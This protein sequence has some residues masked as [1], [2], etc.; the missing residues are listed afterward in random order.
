MICSTNNRR[1]YQPEP[2][3]KR[4]RPPRLHLSN[5]L[6]VFS[7]TPLPFSAEASS[8][9]PL[10]RSITVRIALLSIFKYKFV[11]ES[12]FTRIGDENREKMGPS[13]IRENMSVEYLVW[14][15]M[16][17]RAGTWRQPKMTRMKMMSPAW[18][19][20]WRD[21]WIRSYRQFFFFNSRYC[22]YPMPEEED[23]RKI[24]CQETSDYYDR[25]NLNIL[26]TRIRLMRSIFPQSDWEQLV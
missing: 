7:C 26:R 13:A 3:Y 4:R 22:W 17:A 18:L 10:R 12:Q 19:F 8:P 15:A 11:L 6:N 16:E 9:S 25:Y 2:A 20:R 14:A 24:F 23:Y 5:N 1:L 21:A